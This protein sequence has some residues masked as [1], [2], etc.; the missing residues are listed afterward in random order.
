MTLLTIIRAQK[1]P[2]LVK[3][4]CACGLLQ[5][6]ANRFEPALRQAVC[7]VVLVMNGAGFSPSSSQDNI[8]RKRKLNKNMKKLIACLLLGTLLGIISP[9]LSAQQ[10]QNAQ[11]SDSEI[12]VLEK[13]VS[14]LEKQLQ[15]VEN[16]EKMD[17]QA[18]LVET[19]AKLMLMLILT[20]VQEMKCE[21][22]ITMKRM[23]RWSHWFILVYLELL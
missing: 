23:R 6:I 18:K 1:S 7:Q 10:N 13:R 19:N 16:V 4:L 2:A 8:I 12:E 21:R 5:Y 20:Q 17:L 9:L 15:T 14:E 3:D 22:L 11:K